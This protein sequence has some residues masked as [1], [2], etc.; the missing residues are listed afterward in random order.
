MGILGCLEVCG[1]LW[2]NLGEKNR[3]E[4]IAGVYGSFGIHG[5]VWRIVEVCGGL[6]VNINLF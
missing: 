5:G 4:G 6:W 1:G 2:R 3:E